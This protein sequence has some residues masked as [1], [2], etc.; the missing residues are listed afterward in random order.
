MQSIRSWPTLLMGL[1]MLGVTS[2]S[3]AESGT[4]KATMSLDAEGTLYPVAVGEVLFQGAFR[5][6]M[7]TENP[8]RGLNAGFVICPVSMMVTLGEKKIEGSGRCEIT[9]EG[10]DVIYAKYSCEGKV[11]NC[12]GKFKL[13]GGT[14]RYEGISGSSN[15]EFRSVVNALVVGLASGSTVRVSNAI[16]SLPK[17]SYRIP[18][19]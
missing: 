6:I 12:K 14:G 7:Y 10:G 11:G 17:L 2:Q 1:T 9:G 16:A 15:I 4:I 8:E 3:I 19:K 13:T 5:G 18:D